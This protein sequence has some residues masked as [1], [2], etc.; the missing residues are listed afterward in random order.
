MGLRRE[1]LQRELCMLQRFA[2]GPERHVAQTRAA[3][4][5]CRPVAETATAKAPVAARVARAATVIAALAEL[6][7]GT[8]LA[9]AEFAAAARDHRLGLFHAGPVVATHR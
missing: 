8:A 7:A 1:L 9:I 6:A 2:L 5:H 4:F 3:I